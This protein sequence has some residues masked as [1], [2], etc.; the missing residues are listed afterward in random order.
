MHRDPILRR[1]N[2]LVVPGV[3]LS[4]FSLEGIAY[5]AWFRPDTVECGDGSLVVFAYA[6]RRVGLL[7]L[8]PLALGLILTLIGALQRSKSPCHLGH[9]TAATT[10]LAVL[11]ASTLIPAAATLGL[12]AMEDP[13][14]PFLLTYEGVEY[15]QVRI[16]ALITGIMGLAMIP[17]VLLYVGT[18]RPR[19]C[20]REKQCFEPCFCDE[21]PATDAAQAAAAPLE[22]TESFVEELAP[23]EAPDALPEPRVETALAPAAAQWAA[24]EPVL[25]EEV[26][27]EAVEDSW[28]EVR[29]PVDEEPAM[30]PAQLGEAAQ[31]ESAPE[32]KPMPKAT[33]RKAAKK[34]KSEAPKAAKLSKKQLAQRKYAASMK[35]VRKR[36]EKASGGK[37]K[38]SK[39]GPATKLRRELGLKDG[40]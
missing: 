20:C 32:D 38:I 16:L 4:L 31:D 9:G 26:S 36:A 3:L 28:P 23:E 18:A 22:E 12:Y 33:G 13:A 19:A 14:S 27:E 6:C 7:L 1:R 8:A 24:D 39:R 34:A 11:V 35:G 25:V 29:A 10:G 17:Y 30:E 21:A 37:G 5:A 40:K 2:A 15:G